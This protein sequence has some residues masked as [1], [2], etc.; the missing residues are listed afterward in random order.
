MSLTIRISIG[1]DDHRASHTGNVEALAYSAPE[2]GHQ[3]RKLLVLEHLGG[4]HAFG[5]QHFSAQGKNGLACAI[6]PLLC[7]AA[8]RV[9]FYHEQLAGD[10]GRGFVKSASLPGRLHAASQPSGPCATAS[11]CAAR[12]ASRARAARMMRATM[13]SAI[14]WLLF[15]QCFETWPH[16]PVHGRHHFGIVQPVFRLTL[17][18][19]FLERNTD[20]MPVE[21]FAD[22]FGRERHALRR[23]IVRLDVIT[24]RLSEASTKTFFMRAAGSCRNAIDVAAQL[25][26]GG[27]GPLQPSSSL[28]T[29]FSFRA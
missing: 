1:E 28:E 3:I 7:G 6:A 21:A 13:A 5:V 15:N 24:N 19:R 22:V 17:E 12:L 14:D 26:V 18:L 23:Q 11:A 8:G 20:R 16:Q 25:L 2:G 29:P 10:R 9:A 4:R 27:L